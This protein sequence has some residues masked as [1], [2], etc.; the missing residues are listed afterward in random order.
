MLYSRA[1]LRSF[2]ALGKN[3]IKSSTLL[4]VYHVGGGGEEVQKGMTTM[5]VNYDID[6]NT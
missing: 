6:N 5:A 2:G 1:V 4:F 3:S